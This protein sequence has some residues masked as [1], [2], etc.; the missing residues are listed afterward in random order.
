MTIMPE[1]RQGSQSNQHKKTKL[2]EMNDF[3]LRTQMIELCQNLKIQVEKLYDE[4]YPGKREVWETTQ[5]VQEKVTLTPTTEMLQ[6]FDPNTLN[7]SELKGVKNK[8]KQF[9]VTDLIVY[10]RKLKSNNTP[11]NIVALGEDFLIQLNRC[12]NPRDIFTKGEDSREHLKRISRAYYGLS[13][14]WPYIIDK[15]KLMILNLPGVK[16]LIEKFINEPNF[17]T[18]V[19]WQCNDDGKAEKKVV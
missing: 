14:L 7:K 3:N 9:V 13:E 17:K 19:E 18:K 11:P 10:A 1:N 6:E 15:Q 5:P 12:C 4:T 8:C 16:E 2:Q